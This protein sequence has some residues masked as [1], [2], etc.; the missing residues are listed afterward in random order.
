MNLLAIFIAVI[1]PGLELVLNEESQSKRTLFSL[2]FSLRFSTEHVTHSFG[3]GP[4]VSESEESDDEE[5]DAN[6]KVSPNSPYQFSFL[7]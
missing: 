5:E 3:D 6:G 1:A 7:A 4:A 2:D